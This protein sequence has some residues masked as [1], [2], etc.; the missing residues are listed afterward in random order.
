MKSVITVS[1]VVFF[2]VGIAHVLRL[3]KHAV[4]TVNGTVVP[5]WVSVAGAALALSLAVL[6]WRERRHP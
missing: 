2:A 5:M 3:V 4:V 6:L 1:A